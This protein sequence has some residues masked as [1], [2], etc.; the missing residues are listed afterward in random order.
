ITY[1]L[2]RYWP[3]AVITAGMLRHARLIGLWTYPLGHLLEEPIQVVTDARGVPVRFWRRGRP[4]DVRRVQDYWREAE[5][6]WGTLSERTVYRVE[7]DPSGLC[8]LHSIGLQW[9]LGAIAD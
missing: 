6:F 8:E 3:C 5:W 9:R 2:K 4:R 1:R 7:T